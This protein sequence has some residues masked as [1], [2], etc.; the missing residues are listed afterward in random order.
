VNFFY[1]FKKNDI[2]GRNFRLDFCKTLK[3]WRT[4]KLENINTFKDRMDAKDI[5]PIT[6]SQTLLLK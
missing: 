6:N 1:F 5:N 4:E 3:T 2:L